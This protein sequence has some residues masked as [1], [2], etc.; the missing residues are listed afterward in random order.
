MPRLAGPRIQFIE[1]A[2]PDV[3]VSRRGEARIAAGHPWVFRPDILQGA[4]GADE[5]RVL[6][7]RGRVLGGALWADEPAP[8]ALRMTAR[9][10]FV[11]F[12]TLLPERLERAIARRGG[13]DVCRLVHAEADLL[14]GLFVDRY[15][16]AATIQAATA[17]IDRR[18]REIAEMLRERLGLRACVAR[19]DGSIPDH[20]GPPRRKGDPRR[21]G[22]GHR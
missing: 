22:A 7:E 8:I 10:E 20:E 3:R 6:D 15:R 14:P 19:D 17:G 5:V 9:G 12:A 1:R 21:R 16:D 11:P 2:V 13:A 4:A 18:E